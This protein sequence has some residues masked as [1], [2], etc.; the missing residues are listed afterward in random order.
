MLFLWTILWRWQH[1]QSSIDHEYTFVITIIF[2][3]RCN[4]FTCTTSESSTLHMQ[5]QRLVS[6]PS[7]PPARLYSHRCLWF[8]SQGGLPECM[9]GYHSLWTGHPP[10]PGTPLDQATPG[11]RHPPDQA[12]PQDQASP[13]PGPPPWDQAPPRPGTPPPWSRAYW[14][15]QSTSG[16]YAS[17]WNVILVL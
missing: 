8:C 13:G 11:T 7:L 17:Y 1:W 10:G 3:N 9:L 4:I 5:I 6:L 12:P 2:L 16:W 14:E 15:I